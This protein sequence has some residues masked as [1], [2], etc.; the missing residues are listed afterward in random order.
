MNEFCL[1][2]KLFIVLWKAKPSLVL[3]LITCCRQKQG[4]LRAEHSVGVRMRA[5][6]LSF[7]FSTLPCLQRM[8]YRFCSQEVDAAFICQRCLQTSNQGLQE[9]GVFNQEDG[10]SFMNEKAAVS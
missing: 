2:G 8:N 4:H 10:Y 3:G 6:G 7:L 1:D 9:G 5:I